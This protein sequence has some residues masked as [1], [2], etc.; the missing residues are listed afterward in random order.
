MEAYDA[1]WELSSLWTDMV[2]LSAHDAIENGL[3]AVGFT[4]PT[5]DGIGFWNNSFAWRSQRALLAKVIRGYFRGDFGTETWLSF[6][7]LDG[8]LTPP[9]GPFG[10]STFRRIFEGALQEATLSQSKPRA[11]GKWKDNSTGEINAM[12][13]RVP[14]R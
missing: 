13:I 11:T 8:T 6:A 12:R 1:T 3:C 7:R 5:Y 14:H 4:T 10:G 9:Q 2:C